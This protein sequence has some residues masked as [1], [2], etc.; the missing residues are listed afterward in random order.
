MNDYN[1]LNEYQN[2]GY[3]NAATAENE[4]ALSTFVSK[5][6]QQVYPYSPMGVL[7]N[8]S[9]SSASADCVRISTVLRPF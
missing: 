8:T 3:M 5:V 9:R 7:S 2:N 1:N 4:L 6:M